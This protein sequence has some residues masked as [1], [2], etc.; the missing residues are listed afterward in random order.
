MLL[1]TFGFLK[2]SI[3]DALDILMVALMIFIVFRWIRQTTAMNIFLAIFLL[4][5]IGFVTE[6]LNMKLM[7]GI[8]KIILNVGVIALIVIFQ[9]EI[10]HFLNKIGGRDGIAGEG[11]K[12]IDK[13]LGRSMSSM[14]DDSTTELIE[15]VKVMAEQKTGALIVISRK[16]SLQQIIETGDTIDANINMRLILNLF[17]KNSP[18][19]DGA[20]I[21][22]GDRIVAAR[23]T[24]PLTG[25]TNIPARFGMRHKAAIGVTEECDAAVI[26]VSEETGGVSFVKDGQIRE[27]K[28][29]TKLRDCLAESDGRKDKETKAES[30]GQQA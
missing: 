13:V 27:V 3:T 6:N 19:H 9:P 28:D 14:G 18:L 10:R 7:S 11:R 4:F 1:W 29:I 12:I 16:D 8:M 22:N 24:L 26:V 25:K 30:E 5:I 15:A 23:C 17:F 21:F 2:F 20:V